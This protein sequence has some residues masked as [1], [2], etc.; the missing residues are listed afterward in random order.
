MVGWWPQE[1]HDRLVELF[2]PVREKMLLG[3][4]GNH[5]NGIYKE[6]GLDF[7]KNLCHRIGIP[8]MGVATF[9][10]L[11]VNRSSYDLYVHH[12]ID[13]GVCATSEVRKAEQVGN[14]VEVDAV[15]TAHSHF[16]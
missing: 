8:Y 14:I 15:L 11:V 1:Q 13:S 16:A 10:N 5:G 2:D 6:T 9:V 4:R 3:V 7:D 12:G